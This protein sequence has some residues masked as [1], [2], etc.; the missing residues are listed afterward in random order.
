MMV[1]G[2]RA[3]SEAARAPSSWWWRAIG[4]V[5]LAAGARSESPMM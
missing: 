2:Q 4:W 3:A 1:A 5:E